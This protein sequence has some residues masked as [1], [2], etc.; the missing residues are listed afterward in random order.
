MKTAPGMDLIERAFREANVRDVQRNITIND[1]AAR[2]TILRDL[3]LR[4]QYE[5]GAAAFFDERAD[6]DA[7]LATWRTHQEQIA[8]DADRTV[9]KRPRASSGPPIIRLG[10]RR[11][12]DLLSE[13]AGRLR[14]RIVWKTHILDPNINLNDVYNADKEKEYFENLTLVDFIKEN[15][16]KPRG[17][18][19]LRFLDDWLKVYLFTTKLT[20]KQFAEWY[21]DDAAE[22]VEADTSTETFERWMRS[23]GKPLPK[24]DHDDLRKPMTYDEFKTWAYA[25]KIKF[26]VNARTVFLNRAMPKMHHFKSHE[27][28]S[29]VSI[30]A[31][32]QTDVDNQVYLFDKSIARCIASINVPIPPRN[33]TP[34]EK[35]QLEATY[36]QGAILCNLVRTDPSLYNIATL[37]DWAVNRSPFRNHITGET[38]QPQHAIYTAMPKFPKTM[39]NLMR[40][41]VTPEGEADVP[42]QR[43]VWPA[44]QDSNPVETFGVDLSA[45]I[46]EDDDVDHRIQRI[47]EWIKQ[48]IACPSE[49]RMMLMFQFAV[50]GVDDASRIFA[51]LRDA[52]RR[53]K[54]IYDGTP[55]I[56]PRTV[57]AQDLDEIL[58]FNT[59]CL[60]SH[61]KECIDQLL[62]RVHDIPQDW[63]VNASRY[64]DLLHAPI[65]CI[66]SINDA[67]NVRDVLNFKYE[68]W[69]SNFKALHESV[70]A[71]ND[72]KRWNE[73]DKRAAARVRSHFEEQAEARNKALLSNL[74]RYFQDLPYFEELPA[75]PKILHADRVKHLEF[76]YKDDEIICGR[77]LPYAWG[78]TE[79]E[80]DSVFVAFKLAFPG[81]AKILSDDEFQELVQYD[82]LA[83]IKNLYFSLDGKT[84][85]RV[86]K[87]GSTFTRAITGGLLR[88]NISIMSDV[89][90]VAGKRLSEELKK[91][92]VKGTIA[93]EMLDRSSALRNAYDAA[94]LLSDRVLAVRDLV[95]R[96]DK[97]V[98]VACVLNRVW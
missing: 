88:A 17:A 50:G 96:G 72:W 66:R 78:V 64:L 14:P 2:S 80:I 46:Y 21:A 77:D 29:V 47:G 70:A 6:V 45:L 56:K 49:E 26:P 38:Q 71:E 62:K 89:Q 52:M 79:K 92:D 98:W 11:T 86:F 28:E 82:L 4:L 91:A 37:Y 24:P 41:F 74:C 81:L 68:A 5:V 97:L 9:P 25:L 83:T 57:R 69:T 75:D 27:F 76:K 84:A 43:E 93:R 42:I 53:C 15:L 18:D 13:A 8:R 54:V 60:L 61:Q 95:N 90:T 39:L 35:T 12:C 55:N 33:L 7:I 19:D 48:N 20:G 65:E 31:N 1:I 3:P 44:L 58:R 63:F 22:A 59:K 36:E 30:F 40:E 23:I 32:K 73:L 10:E 16:A 87:S 34:D 67:H 51:P 85:H 94:K